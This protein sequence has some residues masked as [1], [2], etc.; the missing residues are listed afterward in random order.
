MADSNGQIP[1][2][3][4]AALLSQSNLPKEQLREIWIMVARTNG[5]YLLKNEFFLALRIIA[6]FQNNINP[7]KEVIT[8]NTLVSLPNLNASKPISKIVQLETKV[9]DSLFTLSTSDVEK[10]SNLFEKNKDSADSISIERLSQ[11]MSNHNID[12]AV[13]LPIVKSLEFKGNR[14]E[15]IALIKMVNVLIANPTIKLAT[16]PSPVIEFLNTNNKSASHPVEQSNNHPKLAKQ[17]E[18]SISD[19]SSSNEI[20][21]LSAV[22]S[23]SLE[24]LLSVASSMHVANDK[25][26]EQVQLEK[27][28]LDDVLTK[29]NKVNSNIASLKDENRLLLSILNE[30]QLKVKSTIPDVNQLINKTKTLSDEKSKLLGISIIRKPY[31]SERESK[32]E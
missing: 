32:V 15:F 31:E 28:I 14:K 22:F 11:M 26:K 7:T 21:R 8:R 18:R 2:V 3:K 5:Q 13:Y 25:I 27:N 20:S 17:I 9:D 30:T 19:A 1:G 4:G 24:K 10:F 29:I 6:Y 16:L 23:D 12:E